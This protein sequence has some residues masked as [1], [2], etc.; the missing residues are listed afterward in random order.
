[1]SSKNEKR[2]D[3]IQQ[4]LERLKEDSL[5]GIPILVEGKKDIQC[6]NCFDI[7]GNIIKVKASGKTLLDIL[8]E[9]EKIK[10]REVILLFD[11]DRRGKELINRLAYQLERVKIIP[12]I[13][14]WKILL[15][16]VGR[17]LKDIEG[18]ASFIKN[19]KSKQSIRKL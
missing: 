16:L 7:K 4:I 8:D 17:D 14:Y 18:L 13:S 1:M 5:K 9:I 6:L 3:R 11:F 19:F 12:N 10:P 2:I 15:G